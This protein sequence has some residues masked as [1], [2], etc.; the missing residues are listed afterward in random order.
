MHREGRFH[1]FRPR[2][3]CACTH[4]GIFHSADT[5][6]KCR[7]EGCDCV[8]FKKTNLPNKYHASKGEFQG[9]SYHSKLESKVAADL[10]YQKRCGEIKDVERQVKLEMVVNK[11]H[12]LNYYVD[13]KVTHNDGSIEYV[14][15]KGIMDQLSKVKLALTEALYCDYPKVR[16]KVLR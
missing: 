8:K 4:E 12:I 10:E 3:V 14:E 7:V 5:T 15:A 16:L 6:G 2:K 13:F 1:I 9:I 11:I